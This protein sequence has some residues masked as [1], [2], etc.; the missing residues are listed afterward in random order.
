MPEIRTLNGVFNG[1]ELTPEMWGNITDPKYQSGLAKCR[2]FITL[3]H[4]PVA[5]RAGTQFVHETKT[6]AKKSR[7]LRFYYGTVSNQP[8]SFAIEMGEGYFRFHT[9]GAVLLLSGAPSAYNGGTTYAI[10][11]LVSSGGINYYSRASSNTGHTP[12]SNPD[13]WYALTGSIYE[14]PNAYAEADLF[15]IHYVQSNDVLTL[16][17][18]NYPTMELRRVGATNWQFTA[19]TFGSTLTAPSGVGAAATVATGTGFIT[20][21]YVVTAVGEADIDESLQSTHATCSNNLLTTGNY[22]TV[23]WGSASGAVRYNVYKLSNGLY[24][25]L[26]Q[27]DQLTFKD[28]NINPDISR[29]PPI[30]NNPFPSST[31]Y[32][33]AVTYFQQ[34]R[35]FAGTILKPLNFWMTKPG[36]ESN[37]NY[38]IPSRDSDA[39][40]NRIVSREAS[41]ILHLVPLKDLI[42]LTANAEL[43]LSSTD[44]GALTPDTVSI[45]PQSYIGA[46][47]VQPVIVN[48]NLIFAASRGGHMREMAYKWQAGGFITG[49]LSLRAP[50]LFDNKSIVDM[51]YSK[52][53]Q[54]IVWAVSSDGTLIGLTYVPEEQVGGFHW[55]DSYTANGTLQ[56]YFESTVV[57]EE[58]DA[59]YQYVIVKRHIN[60]ADVRYV[61][62]FA[63]RIF[64]TQA[65]AFFV[66][67]GLTYSG[68]PATTISGLDHIEGETVNILAD[69]A[70]HP[71]RVVSG[72]Q[73]T[74][75]HSASKVQIG[76]PIEADLQLLPLAVQMEAFAQGRQKN[77][78]QVIVKVA[79]SLG[80]FAGPD[81]DNLTEAKVRTDEEYGTPPALKNGEINIVPQETWTDGAQ[82]C[83]QQSYPLPITICS[84]TM[85]VALGG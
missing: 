35:C 6:S 50:H 66:D 31:N 59:D 33:G 36:T 16:T 74:L 84:V 27:T 29:T 7:L 37:L 79:D 49:D 54:P 8:Q 43:A 17:H 10:G 64:A 41:R 85:E 65:D 12:A 1:G 21:D 14:I 2:N 30:N 4:G 22:N 25:F 82:L 68:S 44:G 73:I 11:D 81:F 76:L 26:G 83:I 18:P 53:P 42:C 51:S 15:S 3:P 32:P 23:T 28:D 9:Q 45:N 71:Q 70:V 75:Q 20:H 56:S 39:I 69:G 19:P 5:N 47:D 40:Q 38:S 13:W 48:N 60:G 24:G 62:R 67:C 77:I 52:S 72:G 63:N 46:S 55:H 58:G 34:R 80:I 57:V 78:N 61:E